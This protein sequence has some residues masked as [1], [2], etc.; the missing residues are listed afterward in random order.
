MNSTVTQSTGYTPAYLNFAR[1]LRTPDDVKHD[2]RNIALS[3][4]FIP[5]VTPY[6]IKMADVIKET[7]DVVEHEQDRRKEYSDKK[8]RPAP[9]IQVGDLVWV[10]TYIL[11][12]SSTGTTS[13]FVPKRDG[14]YK[15]FAKKGSASYE[16]CR[17]DESV[18][19]AKGGIANPQYF[20]YDVGDDL[21]RSHSFI[22]NRLRGRSDDPEGESVAN[23]SER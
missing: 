10:R 18:P 2:I 17:P 4:N 7:R 15:I 14:P 6:L 19:L 16:I 5:E 20:Q 21:Q 8:R 9:E 3:E 23:K 22:L 13:K 11:S 1:E 12:K